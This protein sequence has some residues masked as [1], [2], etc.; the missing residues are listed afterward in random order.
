MPLF[1]SNP[2]KPAATPAAPTQPITHSNPTAPLLAFSPPRQP[3]TMEE[4]LLD[5]DSAGAQFLY[6][7]LSGS[8]ENKKERLRRLISLGR[9]YRT[10][11]V[12][13]DH[14]PPISLRELAHYVF[15]S[16]II[17]VSALNQNDEYLHL[18]EIVVRFV[19]TMGFYD[20]YSSVEIQ[21]IDDR[22]SNNKVK[23][24]ITTNSNQTTNCLMTLDYSVHYEDVS[25]LRLGII[26]NNSPLVAGTVWASLSASFKFTT[27]RVAVVGQLSSTTATVEI[28]HAA[29]AP[30]RRDAANMDV[31]FDRDDLK[32]LRDMY[33]RGRLVDPTM[34]LDRQATVDDVGSVA[35]SDTSTTQ[36]RPTLTRYAT[37]GPSFRTVVNAKPLMPVVT[38][39]PSTISPRT[40]LDPEEQRDFLQQ[41]QAMSDSSS[42]HQTPSTIENTRLN[43][44]RSE[45]ERARHGELT[46]RFA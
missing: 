19:P 24:R 38:T 44:T 46:A 45:E 11:E 22:F 12:N 33:R 3:P 29:L 25:M 17:K 30:T 39:D 34:P 7:T 4:L 41:S 43:Q 27:S 37:P 42:I 18:H 36:R 14:I 32:I 16:D 2:S 6:A 15:I 26:A 20:E 40:D 5:A 9:T 1:R 8:R 31:T 13:L 21:M 28:A 23:R 10:T 35:G